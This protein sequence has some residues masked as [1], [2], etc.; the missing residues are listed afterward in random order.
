MLNAMTS[1]AR[2]RRTPAPPQGPKKLGTTEQSTNLSDKLDNHFNIDILALHHR[3]PIFAHLT[4]EP[5]Q[6]VASNCTKVT[7]QVNKLELLF[8]IPIEMFKVFGIFTDR[9]AQAKYDSIYN[10]FIH[11]LNE[12]APNNQIPTDFTLVGHLMQNL[13]ITEQNL[14]NFIIEEIT[15][16]A[17]LILTQ[18]KSITEKDR[19][20]LETKIAATKKSIENLT[21]TLELHEILEDTLCLLTFNETYINKQ[22]QIIDDSLHTRDEPTPPKSPARKRRKT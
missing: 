12:H 14:T 16:H 18:D 9:E 2:V 17:N 1:D 21:H 8:K 22:T 10:S 5:L 7:D 11:V 3:L 4:L 15:K 19:E 20:I 6:Q 13:I